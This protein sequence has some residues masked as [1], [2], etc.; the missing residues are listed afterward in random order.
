M[1]EREKIATTITSSHHISPSIP[2]TEFKVAVCA[3][4][5]VCVC[6]V[7]DE[8]DDVDDDEMMAI[9]VCERVFCFMRVCVCGTAH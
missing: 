8:D 9:C 7:Y 6:V 1:K 5:C 3:K 2:R 4:V